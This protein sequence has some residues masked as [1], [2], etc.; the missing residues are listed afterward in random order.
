MIDVFLIVAVVTMIY[1]TIVITKYAEEFMDMQRQKHNNDFIFTYVNNCEKTL[2]NIVLGV[3]SNVDI[4]NVAD[5]KKAFVKCENKLLE[6]MGAET[7]YIINSMYAD[8]KKWLKIE[9][10]SILARR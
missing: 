2:N 5:C 9:I 1:S 7:P 8:Y 6:I 3:Y 4:T 10:D